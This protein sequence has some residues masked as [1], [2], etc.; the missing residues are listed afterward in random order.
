MAQEEQTQK[1][2]NSSSG[3]NVVRSC[4]KQKARRIPQRGLG[5]AQLERIRLEEQQKRDG[6]G[7][8]EGATTVS[9]LLPLSPTSSTLSPTNKSSSNI[10]P[11]IP[12]DH[13]HHHISTSFQN[14]EILNSNTSSATSTVPLTSKNPLGGWS[15]T[16]VPILHQGHASDHVHNKSW[17]SCD[18]NNLEKGIISGLDP[19]GIEPYHRSNSNHRWPY[20]S[21]PIWPLPGLMHRAHQYQQPSSMVNNVSSATPTSS[22]Q[23]FQME[24]PSNQNYYGNYNIPMWPEDDKMVG[25]KRA[26]PFSL[27]NNNSPTF[28]SPSLHCKFAP[29][30]LP[31]SRSDD[32]TSCSSGRTLNS[33][34]TY[35]IFREGSNSKRNIKENGAFNGG[36]LSL[37]PPTTTTPKCQSSKFRQYSPPYLAFNSSEFPNFE[38]LTNYQGRVEDPVLL[39]GLGGSN[40]RQPYYS[41][42]P[43]AMARTGQ[44]ATGTVTSFNGGRGEVGHDQSVDLNL[45]L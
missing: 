41:F 34:P 12:V 4:K 36:F 20:E 39:P 42:F 38:S 30:V 9:V 33:E 31:L 27:D 2:S 23:N 15:S 17:N 8:G 26:Y 7:G 43:Q 3:G 21:I 37:A 40:H 19:G 16:T 32:S 29:A 44:D 11:L 5:V 6:G 22:V 35:P 24:P 18:Y 25:M 10:N 13:H 1:C 14:H 45:K 28:L